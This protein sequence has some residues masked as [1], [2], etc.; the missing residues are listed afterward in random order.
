MSKINT[1]RIVNLNYNN[2][3]IKISDEAF[4]F[5]G[6]STLMS[7]RNGGGKTV[8]VQMMTAPFVHKRYRDTKD[9]KFESYFT[10][11]R[12]TFIMVEWVL[13]GEAGYVLTGMMV[14]KNQEVSDG[15]AHDELEMINFVYEYTARCEN[16][17]YH[18]PIINETES[19]MTLKNWGSCKKVFEKLKREDGMHFNYYDMDMPAQSRMYFEKLKQYQINYKEWETIIK[20]INL[21]E[22]GLSELFTD[23]RDE[24][25]LVEKWF[26]EAIE[27]KLNKDGNRILEFETII[28]KYAKQYRD[29]QT[30]IQRM[31]NLRGFLE[32]ASGIRVYA[33]EYV[34]Y[35]EKR[36]NKENDIAWFNVILNELNAEAEERKR[37]LDEDI[38]KKQIEISDIKYEEVSYNIH[39]LEAKKERLIHEYEQIT[40]EKGQVAKEKDRLENK[41]AKLLCAREN[42]EKNAA[43]AECRKIE[44]RLEASKKSEEQKEP[45]RQE[46]GKT[47]FK[48]YSRAVSECEA[49]IANTRENIKK[50]EKQEKEYNQSKSDC[51]KQKD[52][53]SLQIGKCQAKISNYDVI[54]EQFNKKYEEKLCR[55]IL[56]VYETGTL[57]LRDD[58]YKK[59][60][61]KIQKDIVSLKQEKVKND[62]DFVKYVRK[63]DDL[64]NEIMEKKSKLASEREICLDFEEQLK[65]RQDIMKHFLVSE[66]DVYNKEVILKGAD[67]KL[68]EISAAKRLLERES[69]QTNTEIKL[70]ENGRLLEVSKEFD[71]YLSSMEIEYIYGM[72]WL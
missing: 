44:S 37:L 23:C 61:S 6:E 65:I 2:N 64:R 16:D 48:H 42:E 49:E 26:L 40:L 68:K 72:E 21:K 24:K 71:E 13:D 33:D 9:R 66:N 28:K 4:Q 18:I 46:L 56:G 11:N 54:E 62:D 67:R 5:N 70:L 41:R 32:E 36:K 8:L 30:K 69:E 15:E 45:E 31:K 10:T 27:S 51:F 17:I 39:S 1:L 35:T 25:G 55:N 63:Q 60:M 22:S 53:N 57:E 47:L 3:S 34:D 7:L 59:E 52:D 29:N 20:K 38:R 43:L 19:G 50:Q 12:P 58:E 14:R